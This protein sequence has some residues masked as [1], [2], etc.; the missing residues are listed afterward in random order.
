MPAAAIPVATLGYIGSSDS[1]DRAI[2][3]FAV[4]YA[5]QTE[6]DHEL[7]C[8]AIDRGDLPS[9]ARDVNDNQWLA[10]EFEENRAHL[11]AVAY[12]ML[13]SQSEADDAVQETWIRLQ[14]LGNRGCGRTSVAG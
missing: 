11:R 2:T 13:G 8:R 14:S 7:L 3:E 9:D 5:D 6:R 12:R 10:T 1:F 4:A